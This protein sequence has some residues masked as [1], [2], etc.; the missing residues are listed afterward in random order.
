MPK[1]AYYYR[2]SWGVGTNLQLH[3]LRQAWRLWEELRSK[4]DALGLSR[5]RERCVVIVD[6]LGLSLSQLLGQNLSSSSEWRVPFLKDLWGRFKD[7]ARIPNKCQTEIDKKFQDFMAFY[8]DCRHFGISKHEKIN[9]LTAEA[10]A[11]YI[12]L[13]LDIWDAVCDHFRADD[14]AALEFHSVREILDASEDEEDEAE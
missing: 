13:A 14:N 4:K 7:V 6:L 2:E 3:A 10:T 1:I 9:K 5:M 8:D 12:E 11:G